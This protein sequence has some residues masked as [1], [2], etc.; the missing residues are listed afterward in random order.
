M[1]RMGDILSQ[2]D[3]VWAS[4]LPEALWRHHIVGQSDITLPAVDIYSLARI[5]VHRSTVP[6]PSI[7]VHITLNLVVDKPK[8]G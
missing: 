5:P 6:Q 3:F 8:F 2:C 7:G 1:E 4:H